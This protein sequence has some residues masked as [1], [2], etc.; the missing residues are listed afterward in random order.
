[1]IRAAAR[2]VHEGFDR[3]GRW[4]ALL[5]LLT[6]CGTLVVRARGKHFW[7][8]EVYTILASR[9]PIATLWRAS[10]DGL[11]LAPPLNTILAGVAHAALGVGPVST[12]LPAMTG[13]VVACLLVFAMAR[14]RANALVGLAAALLPCFTTAMPYAY[15][16]RGYGVTVGC[17]ALALFAW[18]EAAAGRRRWLALMTV[19]LTAGVWAHYYAALAFV[20]IASGELVRQIARRRFEPAPWIALAAAA[21]GTL[22]LLP[23]ATSAV[24]QAEHFWTRIEP[25]GVA[26]TYRSALVSLATLPFALAALSLG[27]FALVE[28]AWRP[29]QHASVRR[30]PAHEVTA[31]LASLAIPALG[32]LVG[33]SMGIPFVPRYVLF[34][35][36]GLALVIPLTVWRIGADGGL[37][38]IALCLGLTAV[39]VSDAAAGLTGDRFVFRDPTAGRPLLAER[40]ARQEPVVFAG[41]ISYLELWYHLPPDQQRQAIYLADPQMELRATGSDTIDRGYLALARWT[42]VPIVAYETFAR[43]HRAF[44]VYACGRDWLVLRLR[45]EGA[46]LGEVTAEA[47]CWLYRARLPSRS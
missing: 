13:F 17:F 26:E 25:V 27:I 43:E 15:E 3:H 21:A 35:V 23:L 4:V 30:L 5:F 46:S 6:L 44:D 14:R 38:E 10:R 37:A 31:G 8:D 1:M 28:R 24:P 32:V 36:V 41:G 20:P 39:F 9:L 12:R 33:S 11:D 42:A 29:R 22:P 47:G 16:A 19:A 18:S 45:R 2:A 34:A 7:H 40:L